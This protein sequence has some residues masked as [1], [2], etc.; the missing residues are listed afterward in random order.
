MEPVVIKEY[1]HKERMQTKYGASLLPNVR[2]LE[3][4]FYG[5]ERVAPYACEFL[6]TFFLTF[7]VCMCVIFGNVVWNATAIATVLMAAIYATAPLSGGHLN[8]AVSVA[9]FL[10]GKESIFTMLQYIATQ[11]LAALFAGILAYTTFIF[12]ES[13]MNPVAPVGK[14]QWFE[15]SIVEALYTAMLCF[16]VLNCA[17]SERN[18]PE[19]D[20]NQFY[21]LAI[22]FVI[23]AGGYSSGRISGAFFNPAVALSVQMLRSNIWM[24]FWS[25]LAYWVMHLAGAALGAAFFVVV[26]LE[27]YLAPYAGNRSLFIKEYRPNIII[28]MVAELL[29]TFMI[30][31]TLGLNLVQGN[32]AAAWATGAC[33]M[34][35]TYSLSNVSGAHFNPAVTLGVCLAGRKKCHWRDAAAYFMMHIFASILAAGLLAILFQPTRM[36][37][38]GLGPSSGFNWT[39]VFYAE[40]MFTLFIVYV[41]LAVA[42]VDTVYEV[43]YMRH[44][45]YY[46]LAVGACY[47]LGGV[48]V[49]PFTGGSFNP[50]ASIGLALHR[51]MSDAMGLTVQASTP[52]MN[53]GIWAPGQPEL[54]N[55]FYYTIFECFGAIMAAL[56][57][58]CT[59]ARE[60]RWQVE[61]NV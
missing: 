3:K 50:A 47:T 2:F 46:G 29:G 19:G 52:E 60:Y 57:F 58:H 5:W 8:P 27:D 56:M 34:S 13:D 23:I 25:M 37:G 36:P 39:Q 61:S 22:G 21:A 9:C 1:A 53:A 20:R 16:V 10:T 11:F 45:F 42:T 55:S 48:A 54:V 6:G 7:T 4:H 49:G 59:H 15:A 33:A 43:T 14:Y 51:Y 28:R 17:A 40:F 26:R 44:N 38:L 24:G 41:V 18:N 35:M 12:Y 31:F 30:V 32:M